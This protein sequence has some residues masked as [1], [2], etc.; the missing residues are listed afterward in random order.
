MKIKTFM[1]LAVLLPSASL[2]NLSTAPIVFESGNWTVR[3]T[4]DTMTDKASCTGIYNNNFRI[5]LT[6]KEL[7]IVVRGS[8]QAYKFRFDDRPPSNMILAD[9]MEKRLNTIIIRAN[10]KKALG[11]NR[12]RVS[13]STYSSSEDFDIDLT[14]MADAVETI[15]DGCPGEPLNGSASTQGEDETLLCGAKVVERLK[16]KGIAIEIIQYACSN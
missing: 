3:R 5:Q 2:A 4:I 16:E 6:E 10:F 15:K 14:G 11:S 8:L 7:Y 1:F 12:L 13:A 9:D